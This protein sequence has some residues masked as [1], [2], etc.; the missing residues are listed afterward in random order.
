MKGLDRVMGVYRFR[1]GRGHRLAAPQ[2]AAWITLG[3]VAEAAQRRRQRRH[4][5]HQAFEFGQGLRADALHVGG[6][7]VDGLA[8][9]IACRGHGLAHG[10]DGLGTAFDALQ[11]RPDLLACLCRVVQRLPGARDRGIQGR[12][13][14]GNGAC[15]A[16]DI[17][18][19]AREGL[20]VG[21][22]QH[23]IDCGRGAVEP[24][25]HLGQHVLEPGAERGPGLD[26]RMLLAIVPGQ[27]G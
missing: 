2:K 4:F 8:R 22:A 10:F 18:Q 20:P 23:L 9:A 25:Q 27:R 3:L 15:D 14:R 17:G 24:G 19:C 5:A 1:P 16:G 21:R 13:S 6:D 26:H 7:R 11:H 12:A